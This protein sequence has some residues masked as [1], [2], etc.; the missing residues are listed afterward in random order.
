MT[1]PMVRAV[2]TPD[3]FQATVAAASREAHIDLTAGE[4]SEVDR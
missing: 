2:W 4:T 1:S 3:D